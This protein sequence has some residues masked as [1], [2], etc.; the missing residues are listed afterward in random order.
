MKKTITWLAVGLG[1]A[2]LLLCGTVFANDLLGSRRAKAICEG[3]QPGMRK[4]QVSE[5]VTTNH[6]W[7]H[8]YADST[9]TGTTFWG[10][11]CR[12]KLSYRSGLIK[13]V[14]PMFCSN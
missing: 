10:G 4:R 13:Q 9:I 11:V 7:L 8:E 2:L 14:A 5:I 3:I 12:C 6:G 1:A